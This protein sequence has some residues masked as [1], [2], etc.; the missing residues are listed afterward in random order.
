M[1]KE[2]SLSLKTLQRS[3]KRFEKIQGNQKL[4][5][6]AYLKVAKEVIKPALVA[7]RIKLYKYPNCK[8]I[9]EQSLKYGLPYYELLITKD[10]KQI[11]IC[12]NS[13]DDVVAVRVKS[14]DSS[15]IYSLDEINV[16]T[17]SK[18]SVAEAVKTGYQELLKK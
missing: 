12:F 11:K 13:D 4:Y 17:Y 15:K 5:K 14:A 1:Q 7:E 9:I 3:K 18:I 6:E 16:F 2:T 10:L 8:A